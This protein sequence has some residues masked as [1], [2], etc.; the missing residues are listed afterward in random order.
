MSKKK[1]I[2]D[3]G[4]SKV[5]W[6]VLSD[7]KVESQ[8]TSD[9]INALLAEADVIDKCFREVKQSLGDAD[10]FSEIHYYGAGCATPRVCNRLQEIISDVWK[11]DSITVTSDLLGAARA[12]FGHDKGI[13]C[14]LGTGSNSC[15]YNGKD[16]EVNVPSLGYVLGDEGSGA[17]LGK[18]LVSDT[19]KKHLPESVRERF[20]A[21]YQL[22]LPDILDKV[23]R[24]P[25]PNKFLA[26][27]V[28]FIK[29]NIWNP[30]L[31]SLVHEEFST[32]IKRNVAMYPGAHFLPVS[33]IGSIA[34]V[35]EDILRDAASGQGYKVSKITK[36]PI[37]GLLDYHSK[38]IE[39]G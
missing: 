20:L 5:D 38:D 23:Y 9:G 19:F 17:A 6:V 12:L 33:F 2:A 1:L 13:A 16:I 18:R 22:T 26:S 10:G 30:Y 39:V 15:L 24:N 29:K 27:L 25:S 28:P 8:I 35:F 34:V 7:G 36:N 3:A 32:F 11:S 21:E 37:S 31:Y 14:I 4:S